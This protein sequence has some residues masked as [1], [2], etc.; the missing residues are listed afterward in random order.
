MANLSDDPLDAE[1]AS[2]ALRPPN[3]RPKKDAMV[4]EKPT[5]L[6]SWNMK[7]VAE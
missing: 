2:K 3:N 7:D 6:D 5:Q 1:G 4:V